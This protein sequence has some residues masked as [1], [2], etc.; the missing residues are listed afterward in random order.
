V[1]LIGRQLAQYRVESLLGE[2]GMGEVYVARDTRLGRRVALK[3]LPPEAAADPAR[4]QRFRREARALATLAHPGIVTVYSIEEADGLHFLT[5][6]LAEGRDLS[7]LIASSPLEIGRALDLGIA[8]AGALASAHEAG[9]IHRDLKPRNIMVSEAG[10]PKILDFGLAKLTVSEESGWSE[11]SEMSTELMTGEGHL[12]GTLPY[13]SP[14]Q[15]AG[16][17]ID[18]RTDIFS[19]GALLYEMMTGQ[20]PFRGA[21]RAALISAIL[22]DRP[23]P[24]TELRAD[25]PKGLE[26]IIARCLEK[27][28]DRR[29]QSARDIAHALEELRG[30]RGPGTVWSW[31]SSRPR[32][33]LAA[34]ILALLAAGAGGWFW[35]GSHPREAVGNEP[36]IAVLPLSNL[37]GDPSEQYLCEGISAGIIQRLG[38][39]RGVRLIGRSELWSRLRDEPGPAQVVRELGADLLIDGDLQ[40]AGDDLLVSVSLNDV[41]SGIVA[42]SH[43]FRTERNQLLSLQREIARQLTNALSLQISA[44]ERRRLARDPTRSYEAYDLYLKALGPLEDS[45]DPASIEL[46][47]QLF[48][49]AISVDRK[50][51]LAH[52]GR[53]RALWELYRR[54][55]D[56]QALTEA[57]S[58]AKRALELDPDL[59]EAQVALAQVYRSTGRYTSAI[60]AIQGVLSRHP[61][62]ADALRALAASYAQ[63]GDLD[64]ARSNYLAATQLGADDWRNWNAYGAFLTQIGEYPAAQDAYQHADELAGSRSSL[65][66]Q[67]LASLATLQGDFQR[68]IEGYERLSG[69]IRDAA[70]AS[71]IGTAYYFSDR[72]DRLVK[73]EELYR[74]AVR[75]DGNVAEAQGNLADVLLELGR[76]E[77]ALAHYQQALEIVDQKLRATGEPTAATFADWRP[78]QVQRAIYAA[79]AEHCELAAPLAS[80]LRRT[81]P[82]TARDLHD[83]AYVFALCRQDN[84][85]ITAL[86][87]AVALGFSTALIAR[88]D[89]F[90]R[91]R[92]RPGFPRSRP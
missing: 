67:N 88:E 23:R 76:H 86:Q 1:E 42:W 25:A 74:L 68:A 82:E 18:R 51:A 71:N 12:L 52:V 54:G 75:L 22:D 6:E 10:T 80:E 28:P 56:P 84:A 9:V 29:F 79:K 90:A 57:E 11:N 26:S 5:M 3:L 36:T 4:L 62:P 81:L 85:A 30:R 72:P 19:F 73:A 66:A 41:G 55:I 34:S 91:L 45:D 48:R 46:A 70:L 24:L 21:S 63:S 77:D 2:G 40:R 27:D 32:R 44:E 78:L 89:E 59:A 87:R 50:F 15:A 35:L 60:A 31:L 43:P 49:Q 92:D 14:E 39:L 69:P 47:E 38:A 64:E 17:P 61:R 58:E 83:L 20:R 53:S 8:L 7:R 33:A 13:M 65:P 16:R 37:T